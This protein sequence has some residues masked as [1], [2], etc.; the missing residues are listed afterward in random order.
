MSVCLLL[1]ISVH[2][3]APNVNQNDG[4]FLFSGFIALIFSDTSL[5]Q[6]PFFC[7]ILDQ[8]VLWARE[9]LLSFYF[10]VFP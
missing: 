7:F 3:F 1:V 6:S 10:Y 9:I 5:S 8:P 4:A 2:I